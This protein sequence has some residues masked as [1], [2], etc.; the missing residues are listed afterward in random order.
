MNAVPSINPNN[1]LSVA[2]KP[3]FVKHLSRQNADQQTDEQSGEFVNSR[4]LLTT[5]AFERMLRKEIPN[6]EHLCSELSQVIE[7]MS[8]SATQPISALGFAP[9]LSRF[10]LE[11][12]RE[13]DQFLQN[14]EAKQV[15][16]Q[17]GTLKLI[18]IRWAPGESYHIHGHASGGCVFKV[19]Y[20]SIVERRY[21]ADDQ[22]RLL[23]KNEYYPGNLTY[24][25]DTMG[26]HDVANPGKH[27][28]VTMH[29]YT[30]GKK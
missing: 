14:P 9:A 18:L 30:P 23:A 17:N 22:K 12:K 1:Q 3:L 21:T 5:E 4:R 11:D 2:A 7:T 24:I 19:L 6:V 27:P 26:Y 15:L 13:L 25:D 20:G 8:S 28:A 16:I 29:L 10:G